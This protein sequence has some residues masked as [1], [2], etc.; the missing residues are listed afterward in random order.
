MHVHALPSAPLATGRRSIDVTDA[1]PG[2]APLVVVVHSCGTLVAWV[3]T[4][5]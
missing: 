1:K 2:S 3:S 5:L 4:Q